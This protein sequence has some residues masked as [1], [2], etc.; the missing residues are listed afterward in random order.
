[1]SDQKFRKVDR[2]FLQQLMFQNR[3]NPLSYYATAADLAR[4]NTNWDT[5]GKQFTRL[6]FGKESQGYTDE[7]LYDYISNELS[8]NAKNYWDSLDDRA[9]KSYLDEGDYFKDDDSWRNLWGITGDY[10]EFDTDRLISELTELNEFKDMPVEP[11]RND[12]AE[13]LKNDTTFQNYMNELNESENRQTQLF[14]DQLRENQMMFADYR[15]QILGQQY[16]QNA[17]LMGTVGSEMS[18]ARRNALE[19]GAS[20]GLRMAENINTSLA[21]QNKQSQLSLETS[22][23]LAQQLLNQ[24]QAAAGIRGDY[25][26]MLSAN[27][28][29]RRKYTDSATQ[30]LLDD[31]RYAYEKDLA[32]WEDSYNTSS[33][34]FA[35][36]YRQHVKNKATQYGGGN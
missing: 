8:G 33:N 7:E 27:S 16:Q 2:N 34:P 23:Q 29:E 6:G 10:S 31:K 15:S 22:N 4:G 36:T 19:A 25:N 21:L 24:R 35:E 1:M 26:S 14:K 17:Q 20:A 11:T 5:V 32:N 30:R 3:F 9:K 12:V 13:E 28:A 18:K